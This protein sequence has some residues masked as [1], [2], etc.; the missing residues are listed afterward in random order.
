MRR[1]RLGR[2]RVAAWLI[3]KRKTNAL[4]MVHR[5]QLLDQWRERLA[6]F[7][8]I[9]IDEI[10]QI[11]G[12]KT[13]RTGNIDVAVIQSL[14][15]D[16]EVNDLVAEYGHVIVDECHHLSA[17]T[18]ERVMRQIK[19]KFVVGLTATPTRKDGHHPIIYMQCGPTRYSLGVRAMTDS[20]PF[21]HL[22]L[23]RFTHFRM[24][25][26]R[27]DVTIQDVYAALVTDEARNESIVRD[28]IHAVESGR[29]PL[30]LTGRT[31]HLSRLESASRG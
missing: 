12:G 9:P 27:A 28:V 25:G 17:F 5:Q 24:D 1:R 2:R 30:V 29:S 26:D 22:V 7:L 10:G 18:F 19:A 6:M 13:K 14:H 11:G 21:D 23:P 8:E 4:V 20:T 3:A 15:R 16:Q 31:D